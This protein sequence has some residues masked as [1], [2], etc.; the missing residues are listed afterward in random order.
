MSVILL[1]EPDVM[2]AQTYCKA[3]QSAG[4][5]THHATTAQAAIDAAD[6]HTPDIIIL[7]L[8][9]SAH[10]GVEFLYELRSYAEW[11]LTPVII[12]SYTAPA[13]L[14]AVAGTLTANLGVVAVLYKPR[15]SLQKLLS[16][17]QEHAKGA[18]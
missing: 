3:L 8:Q 11:Q 7:E 17:V 13:A 9:L 12:Q 16:T 15:T 4:H 5:E 18:A 2:L 1:V 10:N 6:E 14:A